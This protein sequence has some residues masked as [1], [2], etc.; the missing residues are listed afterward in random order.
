MKKYERRHGTG[1]QTI[2]FIMYTVFIEIIKRILFWQQIARKT[3]PPKEHANRSLLMTASLQRFKLRTLSRL[4]D[5]RIAR[6]EITDGKLRHTFC[7]DV[8]GALDRTE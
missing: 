4:T 8:W 2:Y 3:V 6:I 7:T 1:T 5:R